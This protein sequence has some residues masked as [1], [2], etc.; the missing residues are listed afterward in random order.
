MTLEEAAALPPFWDTPEHK[1]RIYTQFE[2]VQVLVKASLAHRQGGTRQLTSNL[3]VLRMYTEE[4][5]KRKEAYDRDARGGV[6]G[7]DD[8][9]SVNG[10]SAILDIAGREGAK[11]VGV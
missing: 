8:V 11:V 10:S 1:L 2:K 9:L 4:A 6:G 3:Q 7:Q 5:K